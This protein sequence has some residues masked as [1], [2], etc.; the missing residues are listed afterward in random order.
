MEKPDYL[1]LDEPTNAVDADGVQIFYKIIREEA[2]R[3]TVVLVSS[4]VNSDIK[5]LAEEVFQM[6]QGRLRKIC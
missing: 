4:H 6:E 2:K 3:G 1:F 5:E